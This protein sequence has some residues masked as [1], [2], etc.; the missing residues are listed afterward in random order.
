MDKCAVPIPAGMVFTVTTG[1]YSDYFVRGVFRAKAEIDT[2][3][4]MA[5][6]LCDHPKQ[7]QAYSF[8]E[9]EFLG[10]VCRKGLIEPIDSFEWHLSDYGCAEDATCEAVTPYEIEPARG[11]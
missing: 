2:S 6:W 5:E 11:G 4:L 7:T 9:D 3:A 1:V 8:S 10:W